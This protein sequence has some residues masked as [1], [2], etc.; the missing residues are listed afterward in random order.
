[1]CWKITLL[2]FAAG[3][4]K[5]A[6]DI[7]FSLQATLQTSPSGHIT[8][9]QMFNH[10]YKLYSYRLVVEKRAQC[11]DVEVFCEAGESEM[12]F[13]SGVLANEYHEEAKKL[14]PHDFDGLTL[15]AQQCPPSPSIAPVPLT[16]QGE[17]NMTKHSWVKIR[18]G[19]SP[20]IVMGKTDL[21]LT[22]FNA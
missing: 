13:W 5:P 20:V 12:F 7:F 3:W 19:R 18:T 2:M 17:E 10:T 15:A 9:F 14:E 1:M 22:L 16:E 21:T 8:S 11:S 4:Q 6:S